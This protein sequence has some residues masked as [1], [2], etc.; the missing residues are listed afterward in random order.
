MDTSANPFS[1]SAFRIAPIEDLRKPV[2]FAQGLPVGIPRPGV[3]RADHP[4]FEL[5][6]ENV[7]ALEFVNLAPR[8]MRRAGQGDETPCQK[9]C[10]AH[11]ADD[12][13]NSGG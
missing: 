2:D 7:V 5:G 13:G 8:R 6:A 12:Y 9:G 3:A 11:V 10:F 4:H 1:S